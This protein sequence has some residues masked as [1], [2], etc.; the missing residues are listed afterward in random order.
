MA[1]PHAAIRAKQIDPLDLE[2]APSTFK[3]L[4]SNTKND[5]NLTFK[6]QIYTEDCQSCGVCVD[7]CPSKEKSL[8]MSPIQE[9]RDKGE[10]E[11]AIFFDALPDNVLDGVKES[12]YKGAQFKNLYLSF[13]EHVRDVVKH[14]TLNSF[15]SC[16]VIT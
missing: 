2:G 12:T 16:T 9:E 3:T 8:V 1:C 7:V 6:I 11:N 13:P 15:P 5:R 4:K 10:I 14:L